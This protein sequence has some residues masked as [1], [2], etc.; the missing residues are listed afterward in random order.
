MSVK[1]DELHEQIVKLTNKNAELRTKLKLGNNV[2]FGQSITK[3]L[4]SVCKYGTIGYIALCAQRSIA[5]LSG[6]TTDANIFISAF[7]D[8]NI[9]NA[10][11]TS[12]TPWLCIAAFAVGVFGIIYGK[13]QSNL[14]KRTVRQLH[15]RIAEDEANA[16]PNRT[17]SNLTATGDTNPEDK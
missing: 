15:R 10:L 11:T 5:A 7:A 17:S 13:I 1:K 4:V 8:F 6:E 3:V 9:I 12:R 2:V 14:R 16:D